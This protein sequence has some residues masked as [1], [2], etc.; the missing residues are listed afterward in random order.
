[1]SRRAHNVRFARPIHVAPSAVR[2]YIAIH[3]TSRESRE[4]QR[5]EMFEEAFGYARNEALECDYPRYG[6]RESYPK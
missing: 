3:Q 6:S 1:M 2:F 5:S 4:T